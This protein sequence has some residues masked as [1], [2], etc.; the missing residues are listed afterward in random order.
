MPIFIHENISRLTR[1]IV[2][3]N[4]KLRN[5]LFA[6]E[7]LK[8]L[9]ED[10]YLKTGHVRAKASESELWERVAYTVRLYEDQQREQVNWMMVMQQAM[11]LILLKVAQL[12][13]SCGRTELRAC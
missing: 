9:N 2:G 8:D 5:N 13:F 11:N 12:E 3:T 4:L 6:S 7:V 10:H 1:D